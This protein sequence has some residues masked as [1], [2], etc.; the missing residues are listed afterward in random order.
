M[1]DISYYLDMI[2][3]LF[4]AF[5]IAFQ[6]P[7]IVINLVRFKWLNIE[8][9]KSYR[10]YFLLLAFIFGAIF[11]PPDVISQLMLAFP[12]YLLYEIGLFFAKTKN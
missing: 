7:L 11:T 4:F 6:V 8:K 5:G 10:S 3:S 2:I 12:V 9:L 1:I